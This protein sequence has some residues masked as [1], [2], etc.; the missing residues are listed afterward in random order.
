MTATPQFL[1]GQL[2]AQD[3][4]F[5][6]LMAVRPS[7]LRPLTENETEALKQA[8]AGLTHAR[9]MFNSAHKVMRLARLPVNLVYLRA[10]DAQVSMTIASLMDIAA[11]HAQALALCELPRD[12]A[13]ASVS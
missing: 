6:A 5:D 11:N 2:T 8:L 9:E 13:H 12:R 1:M 7:L 3:V 4:E 10:S